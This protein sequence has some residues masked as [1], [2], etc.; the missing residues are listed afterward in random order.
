LA[1]DVGEELESVRHEA[2]RELIEARDDARIAHLKAEESGYSEG[3]ERGKSEGYAAGE[4]SAHERVRREIASEMQEL[5]SLTGRIVDELEIA[6]QKVVDQ[7][8]GEMLT[9]AVRLAEKIV[10]RIAAGDP[11]SAQENLARA[12]KLTEGRAHI[13]VLVNPGQLSQ[14]RKCC[15]ELVGVLDR[16][17]QVVLVGDK[18]VGPGGVKLVTRGG[19]I[20]AT[21]ETQLANVV[22]VL[23]GEVKSS[24]RTGTY[25]PVPA[26]RSKKAK[27]ATV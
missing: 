17:E 21:I 1:G 4:R 25:R 22:E 19:E 8:R 3:F 20:D 18:D 23:L 6:R 14:L 26:G 24:G 9:F 27:Y 2:A 10:K 16:S 15:T 11:R 5:I 7:A 12:L 13:S